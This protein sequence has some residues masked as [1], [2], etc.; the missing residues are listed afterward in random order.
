MAK[1]KNLDSYFQKILVVRDQLKE[2][3]NAVKAEGADI[4]GVTTADLA[5]WGLGDARVS[6]ESARIAAVRQVR[7]ALQHFNNSSS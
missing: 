3:N 6:Y 2:F 7:E 4:L 1:P 5:S